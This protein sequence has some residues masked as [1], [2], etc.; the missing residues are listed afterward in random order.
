MSA[1]GNFISLLVPY[2]G[3][4]LAVGGPGVH[5]DGTL[6]AEQLEDRAGF[7]PSGFVAAGHQPDFYVLVGHVFAGAHVALVVGEHH[8][9]FA[10]GGDVR[11][12]SVP[13]RVECHL[14]LFGAI[15][16]HAPGLH[17]ARTYRIEPDVFAVAV[18]FRAVVQPE[19]IRESRL[20]AAGSGNRVDVVFAITFGAVGERFAVGCNAVQVAW[21]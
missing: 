11:E 1:S 12:P 2:V 15:G 17:A 6:P 14:C 21:G 4:L 13:M 19:R 10:V 9:F 16:L 18:V 5:V 3:E 7:A 8:D 20:V